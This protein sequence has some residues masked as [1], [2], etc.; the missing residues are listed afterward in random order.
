[1]FPSHVSLDMKL[2]PTFKSANLTNGKSTGTDPLHFEMKIKC[3]TKPNR[4]TPDSFET[5]PW[6]CKWMAAMLASLTTG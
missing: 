1:M 3:N 5:R 6:A 4:D 2:I